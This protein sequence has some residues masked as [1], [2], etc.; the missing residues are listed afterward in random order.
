MKEG[1]LEPKRLITHRMHFSE[2]NTAYEMIYH[3]EK[4]MMGVIFNW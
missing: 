4:N 1:K 2:I 3:R